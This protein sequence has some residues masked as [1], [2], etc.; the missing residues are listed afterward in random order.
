MK[1]KLLEPVEGYKWS[2][3]DKRY[4][5]NPTGDDIPSNLVV[6]QVENLILDG[7]SDSTIYNA[8]YATYG[9]NSYSARFITRKAHSSLLKKEES[10]EANILH[11]QNFRLFKLYR[12]A[13]EKG[14]DKTALSIL[15]EI[16]KLN[17]LYTQKIEISSNIYTLDLGFDI[18]DIKDDNTEQEN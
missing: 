1:T 15:A 8:L 3:Y 9:L 13:L 10:Q 12:K 5:I 4:G 2:N 17:K 7:Y 16:N 18:K 6:E 14:D 11:K